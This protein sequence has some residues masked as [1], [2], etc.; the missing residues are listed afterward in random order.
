VETESDVLGVLNYYPA[1]Q[2][3]NGHLRLWEVAGTAH[4]DRVQVGTYESQLGCSVPINSGQQIF[5]L[6]SALRHLS[7]WAA[8]GA[9]PPA[10]RFDIDTS[11]AKPA[12]ELDAN[13][14]VKGGV[15]TPSVDAPVA[16]LSGIAPAGSS[17]ICL[18]M[19]STIQLSTAELAALYSSRTA[20]VKD[21]ATATD[22]AISAGFVLPQDR[23]AVIADAHPN[24]IAS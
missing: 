19:G 2:P 4:A 22:S 24:L 9:A 17:I 5:V 18:L 6:R 7:L 13:G 10:A 15:R 11:G 8:G 21:Y 14:N 1:V 20:Y 12:Y 16:A 23:A 3:D